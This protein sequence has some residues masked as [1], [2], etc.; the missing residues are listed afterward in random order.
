MMA[1][2]GAEQRHTK[3]C[4]QQQGKEVALAVIEKESKDPSVG[5]KRRE[6]G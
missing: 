5:E 3:Q 1:I 4:K 2:G 6:R